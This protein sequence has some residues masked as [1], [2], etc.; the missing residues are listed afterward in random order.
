M[1]EEEDLIE[2]LELAARVLAETA[3]LER[4]VLNFWPEG[5]RCLRVMVESAESFVLMADAQARAMGADYIMD[6][7]TNCLDLVHSLVYL[8]RGITTT[9][10]ATEVAH[11]ETACMAVRNM[12][13]DTISRT[14][15]A[16]ADLGE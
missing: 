15:T 8:T 2:T 10:T 12:A 5:N 7:T 3:T 9:C 11:L 4:H 14:L 6:Q 1:T 16:A 13:L